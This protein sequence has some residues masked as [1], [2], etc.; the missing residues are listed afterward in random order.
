M[1]K[2]KLKEIA[3]ALGISLN[4][5]LEISHISTDTR[6]IVPGS[7][8]I[9]LKGENFDGHDF[10]GEAFKRGAVACVSSKFAN[11]TPDKIVLQV[12]DTGEALLKLA[13]A[14][15]NRFEVKVVGITG[16][17]GKTTTK[18][19]VAGALGACCNMLKTE[20]NLNNEVGLPKTLFA[21]DE[22]H[23]V[24]V[25]EMGMSDMGEIE[26]LSKAA[27]PD[28][29]VLTNIGVSH[30][31]ALGTREN[32][33]KAKLEIL[34]GMPEGAPLVVGGDNDLL[35]A[36]ISPFQ[37][38][39][40]IVY[41]IH[42]KQA[43]VT[44]EDIT[45][46]LNRLETTFAVKDGEDLTWCTIPC[47]GEHNVQSALATYCVAKALGL[48]RR[49]CLL[50]LSAYA[51][52]GMRQ[53]IVS[54]GPF[55]IVEDC[56]NASPDS[57]MAALSTLSKLKPQRGG[58]RI[59]VLGDMLEL[60]RLSKEAHK[61]VGKMVAEGDVDILFTCAAAAYYIL[62]GAEEN[63]FKNTFFSNDK[64][65]IT[66]RLCTVLQEGDVILFKASRG[67]GLEDVI[68]SLYAFIDENY[69]GGE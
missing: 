10:M 3:Q 49:K 18:D 30:I 36:L 8:F 42:N 28:I 32:I 5:E 4:T 54:R 1:T 61:Q 46:N 19:M 25:V 48:D 66:K 22:S 2:W 37:G 58:R 7:V 27:R 33:L 34:Q 60:G 9:A 21:I 63:G 26:A 16:S 52:S 57:M 69:D 15:R 65:E 29:G 55:K 50:E 14:Y 56:Y 44:A 62:E 40:L 12:K 47:L 53:C 38:H 43:D 35:G 13:A 24:A 31:E 67:I 17:V 51:P 59:A 39:P 41:G 64:K 20:G 68:Y 45:E 6:D 23:D 11:S